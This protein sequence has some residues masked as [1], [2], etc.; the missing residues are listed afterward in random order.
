VNPTLMLDAHRTENL[1]PLGGWK[2]PDL[3]I[4]L[5]ENGSGIKKPASC[6]PVLLVWHF[7]TSKILLTI[8]NKEG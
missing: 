4:N 7:W 5:C 8:I 1:V 2:L 6:L 3:G